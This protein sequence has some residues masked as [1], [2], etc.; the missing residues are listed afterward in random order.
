[1]LNDSEYLM[2]EFGDPDIFSVR[3]FE[4]LCHLNYIPKSFFA[5]RLK[6]GDI[7]PL[8]EPPAEMIGRIEYK[9]PTKLK[10]GDIY[11]G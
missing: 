1:M 4:A 8:D 6:F 10:D 7:L 11:F 3:T 9:I 5:T 2:T